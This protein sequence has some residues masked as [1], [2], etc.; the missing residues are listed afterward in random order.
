MLLAGRE[1]L[2][3][4]ADSSCGREKEAEVRTTAGAEWNAGGA[5]VAVEQLELAVQ[6]GSYQAA[7]MLAIIMLSGLGG[8]AAH[9]GSSAGTGTTLEMG[10]LLDSTYTTRDRS[11]VGLH[12]HDGARVAYDSA[13]KLLETLGRCGKLTTEH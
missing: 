2:D 7:Y 1:Q 9:G 6:D 5:R 8:T 13:S 10:V 11:P 4:E 12:I 3:W